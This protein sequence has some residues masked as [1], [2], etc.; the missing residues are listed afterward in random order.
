MKA[1]TWVIFMHSPTDVKSLLVTMTYFLLKTL[2]IIRQKVTK[3]MIRNVKWKQKAVVKAVFLSEV[4]IKS[5]ASSKVHY[6][7][8]Y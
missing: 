7:L 1:Q 6:V 2:A 5:Y 3:N 8:A 4:S